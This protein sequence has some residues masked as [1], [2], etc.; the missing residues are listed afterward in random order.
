MLPALKMARRPHAQVQVD[1]STEP[2]LIRKQCCKHFTS[3]QE[4][5]SLLH[6]CLMFTMSLFHF[7]KLGGESWC[8]IERIVKFQL[9]SKFIILIRTFPIEN[10][11][12]LVPC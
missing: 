6:R 4:N 9:P 2:V 3:S 11:G 1:S 10:Y 5:L 8:H 12:K 7:R